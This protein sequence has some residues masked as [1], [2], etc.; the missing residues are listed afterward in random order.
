MNKYTT[1]NGDMDQ[2]WDE[3]ITP[4]N[5]KEIYVKLVDVKEYLKQLGKDI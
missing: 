5:E 2:I 4:Q 3:E 1:Y